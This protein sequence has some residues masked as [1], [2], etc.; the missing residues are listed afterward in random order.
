[1]TTWFI[2]IATILLIVA[3]IEVQ[4]WCFT[5]NR[6]A[7]WSKKY[8]SLDRRSIN[9]KSLFYTST[10]SCLLSFLTLLSWIIVITLGCSCPVASIMFFVFW[11]IAMGSKLVLISFLTLIAKLCRLNKNYYPSLTVW[12]CDKYK[13]LVK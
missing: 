7:W 5:L 3:T 10:F 2:V 8:P 1:M 4:T 13:K 9:Y 12:L 6:H 11:M